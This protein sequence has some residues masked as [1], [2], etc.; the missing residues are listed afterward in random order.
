MKFTILSI[1][2]GFLI[3]LFG[4]YGRSTTPATAGGMTGTSARGDILNYDATLFSARSRAAIDS[5][6]PWTPFTDLSTLYPRA[7]HA[8][9][10]EV[11]LSTWV[12]KKPAPM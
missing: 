10:V 8:A 1:T 7:Q 6:L 3:S 11:P 4:V 12:P 2:L 5:D 9:D